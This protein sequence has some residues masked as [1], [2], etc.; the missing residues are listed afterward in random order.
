MEDGKTTVR[1]LNQRLQLDCMLC[2]LIDT[3]QQCNT[4]FRGPCALFHSDVAAGPEQHHTMEAPP[5]PRAPPTMPSF[6]TPTALL[7]A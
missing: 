1:A 3:K 5:A 6:M 4:V 7:C 2:R